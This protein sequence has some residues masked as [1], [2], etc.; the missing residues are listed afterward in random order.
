MRK[1]SKKDST[2]KSKKKTSDSSVCSECSAHTAEQ[3]ESVF[4]SFWRSQIDQKNGKH[5]HSE[6]WEQNRRPKNAPIESAACQVLYY[7]R[8]H[9][10]TKDQLELMRFSAEI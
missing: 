2:V 1:A 8:K 3:T 7:Q 9:S 5:E 6:C 4:F 10:R